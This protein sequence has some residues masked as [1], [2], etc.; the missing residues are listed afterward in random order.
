M[1]NELNIK[2]GKRRGLGLILR[3]LRR[4]AKSLLL[5]SLYLRLCGSGDLLDEEMK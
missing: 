5:L 4:R 3:S 2:A 1:V